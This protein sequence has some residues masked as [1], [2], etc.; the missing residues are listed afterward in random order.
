MRT[1]SIHRGTRSHVPRLLALTVA[2]ACAVLVPVARAAPPSPDADPTYMADAQ[3][4]AILPARG[5]IWIGG[6]FDHLLTSTGGPGPAAPGIAALDPATGTPAKGVRLPALGGHGRFVYDFAL[7]GK[8]LYAAGTFTYRAHGKTYWNLIGLN[9]KTGA[10]VSRFRTPPLRC[11]WATRKRILVGGDLLRAYQPGGRKIASFQPLVPKIDPSLRGHATVSQIRDIVTSGPSAF[12]AGQFDYINGRPQKVVVKFNPRTGKVSSWN[13]AK[14]PQQ[15]GAFGIQVQASGSRLFVGA[16]GSDF[17]AAYSTADG[18][19]FWKTDTSGSTQ[20]VASW[21]S[22]MLVIGGHF[23]WVQYQGSGNCG[24]NGNPNPS[25]LH[26][27]RLAIL[28]AAT[29]RVD[30]AWRP[31]ICCLY[32]GVWALATKGH[33]LHVGGQFTKA[34]GRSQWF[35]ARFS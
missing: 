16:G 25:C 33:R 24:D 5:R 30:A 22:D 11:V 17:T 20:A 15:S 27:P 4:R 21:G 8:T 7:S 1:A 31:D 19:Q 29:G 28:D 3:V 10:V 32:N 12:A 9:A 34:G 35:Y 13:V 18:R 6:A 2:V 14:I 23:Q 26:Q